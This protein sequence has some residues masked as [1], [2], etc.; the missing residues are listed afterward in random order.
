MKEFLW[1]N[2]HFIPSDPFRLLFFP[3]CVYAS[4]ELLFACIDVE[5]QLKVKVLDC[6]ERHIDG[7]LGDFI[8]CIIEKVHAARATASSAS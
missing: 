1:P 3:A 2:D 8:D 7:S 4:Q 5:M 6:V